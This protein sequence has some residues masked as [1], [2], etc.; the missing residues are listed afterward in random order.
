LLANRP[1]VASYPPGTWG[2]KQ[3]AKLAAP[4]KWLLGQ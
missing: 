4:G 2:P 1:R 3:A